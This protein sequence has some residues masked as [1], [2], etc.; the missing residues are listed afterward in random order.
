MALDDIVAHKRKSIETSRANIEAL[1]KNLRPSTK[2]LHSALSHNKS[3][4]IFEIK[5]ASPSKGVIRRDVDIL[6]VA[7]I[8]A[9]FAAAISVLA[10]EKYF[11]GSYQNVKAVSDAHSCPVLCKDVVVSPWQIYEARFYG[12]DAVLL[13]LSVL[14]DQT[15]RHCAEAATALN[16]DI[17][18]EV[19]TSQELARAHDLKAK[20]IGIN[21]RNLKTLDIDPKTTERLLPLIASDC[22]VISESGFSHRNQLLQLAGRVNGF[23]IGTSLMKS[24]RIDLALRELLFGR[25]KICGLTNREDAYNAYKCGAYYGGLN[26][27]SV[28]KRRVTLDEARALKKDVPLVFG[29]VFV[30]Q[31]ADEIMSMVNEL[32]LDFVQ[33]H[34]DETESYVSEL[35]ARLPQG[36]EL[37]QA[38][39]V[40]KQ[41]SSLATKA[42]RIL[43][44]SFSPTDYGGTGKTFDWGMLK[45]HPLRTHIILAG[46]MNA[47]N[48]R[49]A[50]E[51]EPF[52]LDI[53]SGVEDNNPRKKSE[54]KLEQ[55]FTHLWP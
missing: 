30:N 47:N 31:S 39:R 18:T 40:D 27:S 4:F 3:A 46:G 53:A 23:L 12:A 32:S 55:L 34:G 50:S 20:I 7:D 24:P 2:S 22:L 51:F 36:C 1:S 16:M 9:P 15:Y 21:N 5:P 41:L 26:F 14:D 13:M 8:Y 33:L 10:D 11:G 29:G 48:I 52:A 44:D 45:D 54:L 28:S 35:K 49:A 17:I 6:A 38:K 42:D 19:H 37:W 25:V 43:L